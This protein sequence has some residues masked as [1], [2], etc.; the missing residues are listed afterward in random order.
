MIQLR[1]QVPQLRF[2]AIQLASERGGETA[3]EEREG[4]EG[5]QRGR[6]ERDENPIS[7]LSAPISSDSSHAPVANGV[8]V[9]GG[10]AVSG[11]GGGCVI[12]GSQAQNSTR[13]RM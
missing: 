12:S 13:L 8:V 9:E 6:G 3:R 7:S 10:G 5:G 2:Q 1:I 4:R 11:G